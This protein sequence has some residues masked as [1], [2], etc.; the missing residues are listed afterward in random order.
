M[1]VSSACSDSI[2]GRC[3]A[4]YSGE[5]VTPSVVERLSVVEPVETTPYP[6]SPAYS[7]PPA[8]PTPYP[9]CQ[10]RSRAGRWE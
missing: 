7:S 3:D 2:I 4:T 1:A 9:G 6:F 8:S 5:T 10:R